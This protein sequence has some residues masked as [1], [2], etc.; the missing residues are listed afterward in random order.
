MRRLAIA[1]VLGSVVF[2]ASKEETHRDL[3][4]AIRGNQLETVKKLLGQG[5]DAGLPDSDELTPLMHAALY[6]GPEIL[7][8][9]LDR[10]AAVNA[11]SPSGLTALHLSTGDIRKVRLLLEKGAGINDRTPHGKTALLVAAS[12]AGASDTVKLLLDKGSDPGARDKAGAT[13]LILASE[14]GDVGVMELF[15]AKGS[16]VD[17][18][19][20]STFNQVRFGTATEARPQAGNA[21]RGGQSALMAAAS[22]GHLAAVE[23]LLARGADAKVRSGGGF[24]VLHMAAMRHNLAIVKALLAKGAEANA[25]EFRGL[26]PLMIAASSDAPDLTVVRALLEAGADPN[27]RGKEGET[28]LSFALR[29]GETALAKV[30]I[31]AGARRPEAAA[32]SERTSRSERKAT[33]LRSA[34][35]KSVALLQSSGV[36]FVKKS[37][38]ISCHHQSLPAMAVTLARE[39]GFAVNEQ[40]ARQQ[41]KATIG[42]FSSHR[43]NL[44]EAV[45]TVPVTPE[46]GSYALVGL[47]GEKHPADKNTDAL[48]Y[49]ILRKQRLDGSWGSLGGGAGGRPPIESS[50][51]MMVAL[52]VRA[53]QLYA[54]EG[55]REAVERSTARAREFLRAGQPEITEER[56]FHLLGLK[57]SGAPAAAI[58]KSRD[59]LRAAQRADGG[60]SQLPTLPSDAY[61]TGQALAALHQAGGLPARDPAYQRGVRFLLDSQLEDGSWHVKTR[62]IGFQPYFESGFPHGH[63]QWI[64]AAGTSWAV[65]ALALSAEPT[66]LARK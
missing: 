28:A 7:K 19:P 59:G 35:E 57:W 23:L 20:G 44:L 53:M 34:V 24:T 29:R 36:E 37:G 66:K 39:R 52:S 33:D 30:L 12:R 65:M 2:A 16:N 61:A 63:D 42:L 32:S 47:A 48:V 41:V 56:T 58:E 6:A 10:G 3:I 31:G 43:E 50:A 25:Q 1:V 45:N 18:R 60:W 46:V 13:G 27:T 26:T 14:S 54:P 40:I 15:L 21:R 5:A 9:L 8:T 49:D 17:D 51:F 55:W 4:R 62:A 64:S 38:C 11:K 22:G